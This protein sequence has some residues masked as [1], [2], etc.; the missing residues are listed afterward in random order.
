MRL[1]RRRSSAQSD[2]DL[3]LARI[4]VLDVMPM[5]PTGKLDKIALRSKYSS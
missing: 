3:R 5:T 2:A 4:D 1:R